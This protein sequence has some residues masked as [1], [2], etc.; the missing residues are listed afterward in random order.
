MHSSNL[1]CCPSDSLGS[2]SKLDPCPHPAEGLR[3][4]IRFGTQV[5]LGVL[6]VKGDATEAS[7]SDREMPPWALFSACPWTREKKGRGKDESPPLAQ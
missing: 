4:L 5:M 6:D 1:T 3:Y 7:S 2:G